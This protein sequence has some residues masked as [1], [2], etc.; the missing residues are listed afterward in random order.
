MRSVNRRGE[1]VT[2]RSGVEAEVLIV[3]TVMRSS[4]LRHLN[5]RGGRQELESGAVSS[6]RSTHIQYCKN[7]HSSITSQI[8]SYHAHTMTHCVLFV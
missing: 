7:T 8:R 5:Y 1:K 2:R 6:K 4:V 3:D